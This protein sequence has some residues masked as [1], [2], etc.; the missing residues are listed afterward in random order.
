M[1]IDLLVENVIECGCRL[2]AVGYWI[3][4]PL[5]FTC[6]SLNPQAPR[7]WP[8]PQ[9]GSLQKLSRENEAIRVD[10]KPR[11]PSLWKWAIWRQTHTQG[12]CHVN[13]KWPSTSQR[14]KHGTDP[15]LTT[16]RRNQPCH[17]LDSGCLASRTKKINFKFLRY[18][19]CGLLLQ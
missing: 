16:L 15:S 11:Q 8:F 17:L 19:G 4:S 3:V 10:P 6:L 14:G 7:M 9:M 12:E 5:P 1:F 18:S 2:G 13:V